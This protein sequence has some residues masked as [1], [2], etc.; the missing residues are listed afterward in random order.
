MPPHDGAQEVRCMLR[1]AR[2]GVT[3]PCVYLVDEKASRIFMEKVHGPTVKA[4]LREQ[5]APDTGVYP[6]QAVE[7]VVS[8]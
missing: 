6:Q 5:Y 2:A 4:Y 3:T 8:R 7:V 1:C